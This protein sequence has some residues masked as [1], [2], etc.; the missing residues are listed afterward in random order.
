MSH[1]SRTAASARRLACIAITVLAGAATAQEPAK[2]ARINRAIEML[3]R[4][5]PVYY[6]SSSGGYEDGKQLAQTPYDYI[7][8]EMEH[9]AFDVAA[10]RA[11]MQ[12]LA[13][14][15]PTPTGHRTP[16]VIV[17]LPVL[18]LDE[19]SMR[20][21]YWVIH[22]VLAAGVHGIL[23]CHARVPEAARLLVETVRYPFAPK[24]DGLAEGLR[25]SGSQGFAA[26]I[27]GVTGDQ[28]LRAADPWPLNPDGELL[29]G[30]KIEDKHALENAERTTKVPGI[31]F[32]EWGPG[33]M[34]FSLVGLP[35]PSQTELPVM[36]AARDRVFRATREADIFFLDVCNDANVVDKL[37]EGVMICTGGLEP[38]RRFIGNAPRS[39]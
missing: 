1:R 37:R 2:P 35:A 30:V 33:D 18:G 22:Q 34:G 9:G 14:A 21:N 3:A 6:T 23:L 17:T 16:A 20:A 29:L 13:D 39:R 38:G 32:A 19:A 15:G 31:A 10:L 7:N 4:G 26:R 24:I 11:F 36:R 27:W 28:Y 12:G 25:G 8:Y 5:T